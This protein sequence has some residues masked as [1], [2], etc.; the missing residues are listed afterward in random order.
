M[1]KILGG[2]K[3][4]KGST[5]NHLGF[6]TIAMNNGI[7]Q[8]NNRFGAHEDL[9]QTSDLKK[10]SEKTMKEKYLMKIPF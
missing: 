1:G 9:D 7:L 4:V 8:E 3:I 6:S 2:N 10:K 5:S